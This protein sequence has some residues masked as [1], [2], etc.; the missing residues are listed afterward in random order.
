MELI[1]ITTNDAD[2]WINPDHI[3]AITSNEQGEDEADKYT[4]TLSNNYQIRELTEK[5]L[6]PIW[7]LENTY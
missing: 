1:Y 3:V 7:E 6:S 5:Q 4:L 2:F